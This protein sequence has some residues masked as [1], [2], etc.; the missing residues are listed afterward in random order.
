MP[1]PHWCGQG[2]RSGSEA[3]AIWQHPY[4]VQIWDLSATKLAHIGR[5]KRQHVLRTIRKPLQHSNNVTEVVTRTVRKHRKY[6]K[7]IIVIIA[8]FYFKVSTMVFLSMSPALCCKSGFSAWVTTGICQ[9]YK[10]KLY[11]SDNVLYIQVYTV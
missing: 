2:R 8:Y 11:M 4:P 9:A 5:K 1:E 6:H 7:Q 3:N 10:N